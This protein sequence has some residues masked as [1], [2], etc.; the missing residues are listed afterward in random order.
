MD[1]HMVS[2]AAPRA[3]TSM[4]PYCRFLISRIGALAVTV[5]LGGLLTAVL[6][7]ASPGVLVEERSGAL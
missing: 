7:R 6:V 1:D 4:R 2:T 3:S 5:L